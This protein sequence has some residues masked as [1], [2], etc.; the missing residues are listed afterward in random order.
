G[1]DRFMKE[2]VVLFDG[3]DRFMKEAVVLLDG[4]DRFMKGAVVLFDGDDRF[5]KE[6]VVLFDGDDRFMKE[7]VVLPDGD[8]RCTKEAV[9][10]LPG[11]D[12]PS[13]E[14][15]HRGDDIDFSNFSGTL[16]L[17]SGSA[18]RARLLE[19]R[20]QPLEPHGT[21]DAPH[22]LREVHR[23]KQMRLLEFDAVRLAF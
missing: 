18:R 23:R 21:Q 16:T 4:D 8:G 3:D 20:E 7:A 6:A 5:M 2:A 15:P 1:D 13:K 10:L 12:R 9:V 17:G 22:L 19:F 11:D 14:R